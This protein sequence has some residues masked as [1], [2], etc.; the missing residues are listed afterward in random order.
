MPC[1]FGSQID[2]LDV[3]CISLLTI[4]RRRRNLLPALALLVFVASIGMV[5]CGSGGNN[6]GID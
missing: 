2:R 4:S 6:G 3:A 1:P 5:G